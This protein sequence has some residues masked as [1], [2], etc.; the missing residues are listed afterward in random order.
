MTAPGCPA[1]RPRNQQQRKHPACVAAAGWQT[2]RRAPGGDT[3]RRAS[4]PERLAAGASPPPR[5]RR[6]ARLSFIGCFS[7]TH[8]TDAESAGPCVEGLSGGRG[9]SRA[10]GLALATEG[11]LLDIGVG[12]LTSD[13]T[14]RSDERHRRVSTNRNAG[15]RR[16]NRRRSVTNRAERRSEE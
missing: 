3:G 16:L 6:S 11:A 4:Q 5:S 2:T 9:I 14:R 13:P 15:G 7:A 10:Q 8:R 12:S 1:G